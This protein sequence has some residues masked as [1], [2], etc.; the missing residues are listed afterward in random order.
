MKHIVLIGSLF[1]LLNCFQSSLYDL[2]V[3]SISG[4]TVYMNSF[5]GSKI[6]VVI[7]NPAATNTSFLRSIDSLTRINTELKIIAVPAKEFGATTTSSLVTL[8]QSFSSSVMMIRPCYV[9]K[10]A[11][12]N[13]EPLV[14]WLTSLSENGHFDNDVIGAGQ[15]FLVN[16]SGVLYGVIGGGTDLQTIRQASDQNI[17]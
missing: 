2:N 14:K 11:G 10:N 1:V 16:R 13:Q 17:Q 4:S 6:A 15:V 7:F 9:K 12:A 5:R 8:S 3:Q